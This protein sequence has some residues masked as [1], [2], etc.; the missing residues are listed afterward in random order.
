MLNESIV[1][2]AALEWFGGLGSKRVKI[3]IGRVK[4]RGLFPI[5]LFALHYSSFRRL[6][7]ANACGIPHPAS[8]KGRGEDAR[9]TLRKFRIVQTKGT[10]THE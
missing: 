10:R 8:P 2:D 1:E 3:E 5:S 7:P 9:A 4:F 6:N